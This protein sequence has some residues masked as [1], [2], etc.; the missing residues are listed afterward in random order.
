F[1]LAKRLILE[2]ERRKGW[3]I[4]YSHDVASRPSQFGCTPELLEAVVS[5]G[6]DR[7]IKMTTVADAVKE[8]CSMP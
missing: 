3:L 5:F 2:N 1:E 8:I 6:A 7:G 4:F